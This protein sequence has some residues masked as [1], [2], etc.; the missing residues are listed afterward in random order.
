MKIGKPTIQGT[1]DEIGR[2]LTNAAE[3]WQH[4]GRP[5]LADQ[6]AQALHAVNDGD[7]SVRVGHVEYEVTDGQ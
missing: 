6:A 3:G 7:Y 2:E 4:F 5:D 1:K